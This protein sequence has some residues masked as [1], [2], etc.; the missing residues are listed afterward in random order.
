MADTAITDRLTIE[1][2][3]K[4]I[5]ILCDRAFRNEDPNDLGKIIYVLTFNEE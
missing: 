3:S 4:F 1:K 2:N 5:Q